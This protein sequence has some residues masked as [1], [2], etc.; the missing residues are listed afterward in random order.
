M[1]DMPSLASNSPMP[2]RRSIPSTV[3]REDA[4]NDG[5]GG[6]LQKL[7]KMFRSKRGSRSPSEFDGSLQDPDSLRLREINRPKLSEVKFGIK[8]LMDDLD[9]GHSTL[10]GDDYEEMGR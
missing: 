2:P 9:S 7:E 4:L 3:S 6:E 1:V 8:R 5:L 10:P